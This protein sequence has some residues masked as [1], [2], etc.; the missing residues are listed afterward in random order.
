MNVQLLIDSIVRQTTVLI[1]QLAIAGG[2]RT[3]LASI[4]NQ[5]FV[6]LA[7]ELEEQGLGRKVTA[8]MFGISLRSYQRKVHRLRE[9][10]TDTGR[11]L[12]EAV[13]GHISE[14]GL[15]R[16]KQVLERFRHDDPQSVRGILRDLVESGLVFGSGSQD[17]TM[18]RAASEGELGHAS[19]AERGVDAMVWAVIYRDGPLTRA[20]L[21]ERVAL[22]PATLDAAL[23]RLIHEGNVERDERAPETLYRSERLVVAQGAPA[24]WEAAVYDHL[25]AVVKTICARLDRD[26]AHEGYREHIGGS[27]YSLDVGPDHPLRLEALTTIERIRSEL[28]GLRARVNAHNVQAPLGSR[29]ERVV[30]YAGQCV[31]PDND[32]A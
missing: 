32:P 22:E 16:R 13:Y 1:A 30:V 3:P 23:A 12:W 27:T 18:Y 7:T 29:R 14:N 26:T 15:V 17:E 11:S 5:V 25:Q 10:R 24:G 6:E 20:A 4:A 9:S 8:D 28:S 19:S 2:A 21:R 31:L